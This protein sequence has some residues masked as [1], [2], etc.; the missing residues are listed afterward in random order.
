[1]PSRKTTVRNTLRRRVRELRKALAASKWIAPSGLTGTGCPAKP[2]NYSRPAR[3]ALRQTRQMRIA[4]IGAGLAGVTTAY[5]LAR[6]G[7]EAI[8]YERRASISA[9]GSFAPACVNAPASK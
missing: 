8:V 5:E 1:M 3:P 4:V 9:E 2:K 6:A 7:H